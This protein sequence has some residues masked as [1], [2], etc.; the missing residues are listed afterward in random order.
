MLYPEGA[1]AGIAVLAE[2]PFALLRMST[3]PAASSPSSL[4]EP[5]RWTLSDGE[6]T[7]DAPKTAAHLGD[8][9]A[10]LT[11]GGGLRVLGVAVPA[12]CQ[13]TE[14][15]ARGADL[16]AVYEPGDSRALRVTAMWRLGEEEQAQAGVSSWQLVL[17]AQTSLLESAAESTVLADVA[18]AGTLT[19]GKWQ[20]NAVTWE[21]DG[22]EDA[23]CVRIG[24]GGSG[25]GPCLV[26][27]IHPDDSGVVECSPTPAGG[28]EVRCRLFP[29]SVEKGVLLRSRVLAAL[30][31]AASADDW[32]ATLL[33]QFA[34]SEPILTA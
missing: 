33:E 1:G 26:I 27:A 11:V 15:W 30:G 10:G 34:G 24:P 28:V 9:A 12:G 21:R 2:F 32:S 14:A 8:A 29:S 4:C 17:S 31:P 7:A 19:T 6:A 25:S 3:M 22:H 23:R 20:G 18:D 13:P 5:Q 16:T